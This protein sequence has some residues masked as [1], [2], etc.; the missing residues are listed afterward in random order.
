MTGGTPSQP[1]PPGDR[2]T[3]PRT[4]VVVREARCLVGMEV[5][6]GCALNVGRGGLFISSVR[7]REPGEVH[8]IQFE[9]PGLGRVFR[10]R[11]RVVWSRGYDAGSKRSPGFGLEFLDLPEEDRRALTLWVETAKAAEEP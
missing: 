4:P 9:I 8:D 2:R 10:C 7:R 3:S 1:A 6:F 11:A 5:F